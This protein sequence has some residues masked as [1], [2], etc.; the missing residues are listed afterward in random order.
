[1]GSSKKVTI[2]YK[3]KTGLLYFLCWGP[4]DAVLKI[5][6]SKKTV[7]EGTFTGGPVDI[8]EPNLF[9]GDEEE[10]GV[11][12]TIDIDMGGPDQEPNS[13][14]VSQLGPVSAFRGWVS[15]ILNQVYVTKGR[16][17]KPWE[18]LCQRVTIR[19]TDGI[20]QWYL[21]KAPIYGGLPE[22]SVV[23]EEIVAYSAD[24]KYRLLAD[25]TTADYSAEDYDDSSWSVSEGPFGSYIGD[26]TFVLA[27]TIGAAIWIR[28]TISFPGVVEKVVLNILNDD[29][30]SIWWNG[31]LLLL[32]NS[33]GGSFDFEISADKVRAGPNV[34][35]VRVVDGIPTGDASNI[36]LGVRVT[37]TGDRYQIVDLNPI[38]AVREVLTDLDTGLRIPDS[39]IDEDNFRSVAGT[40]FD[41]SFGI[42]FLNQEQLKAGEILDEITRTIDANIDVDRSTG[43]IIIKLIRSDYDLSSGTLILQKSDIDRIEDFT[44]PGYGETVNSV[45]IVYKDTKTGE[46]ESVTLPDIADIQQRGQENNTTINYPMIRNRDLALR[47]AERDLRALSSRIR[48]CTIYTTRVAA[49]LKIGEVVVVED[50]PE[51]QFD[52]VVFRVVEL[53]LG[54]PQSN[55]VIIKVTEDV[56]SISNNA[57]L[58]VQASNWV[59]PVTDP[60]PV[61]EQFLI[62]MPYYEIVQRDSQ[63]TVDDELENNPLLGFFLACGSSPLTGIHVNQKIWVRAGSIFEEDG[64]MDFSPRAYIVS[65]VAKTDET[66]FIDNAVDLDEVVIGTYAL[67]GTEFIRLDAVNSDSISVGRAVLDTLPITVSGSDNLPIL[68]CQ[69][70]AESDKTEYMEGETINVRL[71]TN[72]YSAN[73]DIADATQMDLTFNQRAARPYPPANL[74]INGS[75]FPETIGGQDSLQ[76]AWNHRDKTQQTS[77]TLLDFFDGDI[78]PEVDVS[79]VL[80]LY[81]EENTLVRTETGLTGKVYNYAAVDEKADSEFLEVGN[82]VTSDPDIVLLLNLNGA[83]ASTDFVDEIGHIFNRTGNPQ[84]DTD[85][86]KFGGASGL[87]NSGRIY[88]TSDDFI[89]GLGPFTIEFWI[90]RNGTAAGYERILMIGANAT[91]GHIHIG[92]VSGT[93]QIEAV[94]YDGSYQGILNSGNLS[95]DTWYHVAVVRDEQNTAGDFDY[96]M[97]LDG[98]E[99]DTVTTAFNDD[100]TENDIHIGANEG[101]T[102]VFSGHLD[103]IRITKKVVYS[104]A[105]TPP[106]I[107]LTDT[108]MGGL[109]FR[110]NG[111]LRF[112]LKSVKTI[113]TT[114]VESLQ[115]YDETVERPGWNFGWDKF[116]DGGT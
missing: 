97:Y 16:Y 51:L 41:E 42:S 72:T 12:G 13:Y 114:E 116:W 40:I 39:D 9:G 61:S 74:T 85:Q 20:E 80:E 7:I 19:Q 52:N 90:R 101:S 68:F 25:Y 27:G 10:G 102:E 113:G 115:Y 31:E 15:V 5:K 29:G 6:A 21:E 43:K 83:D 88:S 47:V 95:D 37:W 81:N 28:R 59:P 109:D 36:E 4:I 50:W 103:D 53:D 56:Y 89:L 3:L 17:V 86:S 55:L 54:S 14:L 84:I 45:T 73:L 67:M 94:M 58:G 62:E 107:E 110:L 104:A 11:V 108:L 23:A 8:D 33:S 26:N 44:Q 35:A 64:E 60:Q 77:G 66:I 65:D 98:V 2:G 34:L 92:M 96:F 69:D 1:M 91:N 76:L 105:F 100:L 78:G 111:R 18:F 82:G 106:D 79:Y 38:H 112:I 22:E 87:F 63:T 48:S 30:C 24:W 99:V 32:N 70:Y 71:A 49:N 57:L 75:Y 46:K 93:R